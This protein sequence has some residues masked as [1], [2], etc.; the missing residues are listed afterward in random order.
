MTERDKMNKYILMEWYENDVHVIRL[1]AYPPLK[2][3]LSIIKNE[4][5]KFRIFCV[6][7]DL[8]I[9]KYGFKMVSRECI[10]GTYVLEKL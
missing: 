10:G 9:T 2:E 4:K 1:R 6:Y 5:G 7:K 3:V 8:T